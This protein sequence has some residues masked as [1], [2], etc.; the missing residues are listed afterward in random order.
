[1]G[2]GTDP[3]LYVA[4]ISDVDKLRGADVVFYNGLY[5]E[6]QLE[7]VL[8]QLANARPSSPSRTTSTRPSCCPR[9]PMPMSS[10]RTSGS[11]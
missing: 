4:S 8:E 3:H 1:M 10:T 9:P 6:A 2:A 11:T 7:D 5:L